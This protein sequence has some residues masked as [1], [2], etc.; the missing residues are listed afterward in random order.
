MGT[1][2]EALLQKIEEVKDLS[3]AGDH[4]AAYRIV[5]PEAEN[6]VREFQHL[7]GIMYSN[8]NFVDKSYTEAVAWL[9][10]SAAQGEPS[11]QAMLGQIFVY[12]FGGLGDFNK[13]M[14]WLEE[15]AGLKNTFALFVL[16]ELYASARVELKQDLKVAAHYL[17]L[18]SEL[19]HIISKRHLA[20]L[21]SHGLGVEVNREKS[22]Q[23]Y[24]EA[25]AE[26][27]DVI[28]AHNLALH[29][30][31]GLGIA[32]DYA[33]AFRWYL[34]A[35]RAGY[36]VA[37][38]NLGVAYCNGKGV[39][40]DLIEAHFW[41]LKAA[42]Q[43][44]ARSMLNIGHL[45]AYGEGVEADLVAALSWYLGGADLQDSDAQLE[46]T[47]L[48]PKLSADE[49]RR[50]HEQAD[51]HRANFTK[52]H[53]SLV[54]HQQIEESHKIP[55][56]NCTQ[57]I[58][59]NW[60]LESGLAGNDLLLEA[61]LR[62]GFL[63]YS[64]NEGVWL[65]TGSHFE[66]IYALQ[67]IDGLKVDVVTGHCERLARIQYDVSNLQLTAIIKSIIA[68]PEHRGM[69]GLHGMGRHRSS[70]WDRYKAMNWGAKKSI[71]RIQGDQGLAE[72]GLD[73][74]VAL[75]VKALPLARVATNYCCDGHGEKEAYILFNFPWDVSW[76]E[77]VFLV[78][79]VGLPNSCW[80][81]G[82]ERLTINPCSGFGDTSVKLMLDDIQKFSRHLMNEEII[83]KI[84]RAR[85]R[86]LEQ[87]SQYGRWGPRMVDF[88][89]AARQQLAQ[90]FL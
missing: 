34:F 83:S 8:G 79:N 11:S 57:L 17:G 72:E 74:G 27:G 44:S 43:G 15:A 14:Y 62:R 51:R 63:T 38:H 16:G 28:A 64:D 5:K 55:A 22:F 40:K 58:T 23:L 20:S 81:W 2:S 60:L 66:D 77:R 26:G 75:L 65:G 85:T 6:G 80:K 45:Y 4:E 71:C 88:E 41:Y 12:D 7:M 48:L 33:Q 90:E 89:L 69:S 42:E 29:Y 24:L 30:N 61:L 32:V 25:A 52:V 70:S 87:F 56:M 53:P 35:A 13:G 3:D 76:G 9:N 73:L 36:P 54:E 84:G 19:G 49:L 18:A 82:D 39:E 46:V 67:C 68:I 78:L 50:A 86:T 47:K 59:S 10:R 31:Y 21:Y 37:Q 1:I